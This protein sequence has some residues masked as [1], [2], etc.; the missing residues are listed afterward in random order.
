MLKTGSQAG[1]WAD[2]SR[3]PVLPVPPFVTREWL[4]PR[5]AA[6]YGLLKELHKGREE[7]QQLSGFSNWPDHQP[8]FDEFID[9][10]IEGFRY[11]CF[12]RAITRVAAHHVSSAS[13]RKDFNFFK[14]FQAASQ[15]AVAEAS[16]A[17]GRQRPSGDGE[18]MRQLAE[19][20]HLDVALGRM[21]L[22]TL[23]TGANSEYLEVA[24]QRPREFASIIPILE[25]AER[26]L[27][28]GDFRDR[29]PSRY[30]CH[31]TEA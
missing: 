24:R 22:M 13:K 29:L 2:F 20:G 30:A 7:I 31:G 10:L 6:N 19:M 17:L 23:G 8:S 3:E 16:Q 1:L 14:P 9:I 26:H 27:R 11:P 21:F 15:R 28:D 25:A 4:A 18:E 12:V 5:V